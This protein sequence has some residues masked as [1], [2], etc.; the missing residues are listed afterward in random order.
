MVGLWNRHAP[1]LEFRGILVAGRSPRFAISRMVSSENFRS[2]AH[3]GTVRMSSSCL[4]LSSTYYEVS[5]RLALT[6][7]PKLFCL[8][9]NGCIL[10]LHL[11]TASCSDRLGNGVALGH[12]MLTP[13]EIGCSNHPDLSGDRSPRSSSREHGTTGTQRNNEMSGANL[14]PDSEASNVLS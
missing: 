4:L 3:S 6:K 7:K 8:R 12:I 14:L 2:R 11:G 13:V 1:R 10:L 9:D 5:R